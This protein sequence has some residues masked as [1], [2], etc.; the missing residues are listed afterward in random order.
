MPHIVSIT[1]QGAVAE[2]IG[3]GSK[4]ERVELRLTLPGATR[5]EA[6]A[7]MRAVLEGL[8]DGTGARKPAR[9]GE[10][11]RGALGEAVDEALEAKR[12]ERTP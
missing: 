7:T 5:E 2:Y 12:R 1:A 10:R 8:A 11:T 4:G 3:P 9:V 6:E